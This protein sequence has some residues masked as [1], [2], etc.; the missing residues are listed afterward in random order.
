[1][2]NYIP[3]VVCMFL[4]QGFLINC[5]Q[6]CSTGQ[7]P[8]ILN[9]TEGRIA[10]PGHPSY[11]P[12]NANISW[13][14]QVPH[15]YSIK[16]EFSDNFKIGLETNCRSD[17]LVI[18]DGFT[19]GSPVM[20]NYCGSDKPPSLYSS[21]PTLLVAFISDNEY[22]SSGFS[23]NYTA[24]KPGTTCSALQTQ[25]ENANLILRDASGNIFAHFN[26]SYNYNIKPLRCLWRLRAPPGYGIK[27]AINALKLDKNTSC[28]QSNFNVYKGY[29]VQ[30][31]KLVSRYC[32]IENPAKI[33]LPDRTA[34]LRV[35][36]NQLSSWIGSEAFAIKYEFLKKDINKC[37]TLNS[38]QENSNII[39]TRN[40]GSFTIHTENGDPD[41]G[42]Q[43]LWKIKPP[44]GHQ[45]RLSFTKFLLESDCRDSFVEIFD[46]ENSEGN[47]KFC[48]SVPPWVMFSTGGYLVVKFVARS[49][50]MRNLSRLSIVGVYEAVTYAK[51][52]CS[53]INTKQMNSNIQLNDKKGVI[54]TPNY[55][56]KYPSDFKCVW[57]ITVPSGYRIR[58]HFV[59]FNVENHGC[60]Y[61]FVEVRD[62]D[63]SSSPLKTQ[64]NLCGITIPY[65][66][67]STSNN[68]WMMFVSDYS[69]Q[70]TGFQAFYSAVT[71]EPWRCSPV[72]TDQE[73]NI[74]IK[75]TPGVLT[76]PNY[77]H[78]YPP[79][80][81]CTWHITVP[82]SLRIQVHFHDFQ[83][84]SS[85]SFE[86]VEGFDGKDISDQSLGRYCGSNLP[87]DM[88]STGNAITLVFQSSTF[89]GCRGFKLSHFILELGPGICSKGNPHDLNDNLV[90]NSTRGNITSPN[91]PLPYTRG[92]Q[93]TWHVRAPIGYHV[94]LNF[95]SIHFPLPCAQDYIEVRDGGSSNSPFKGRFC[96]VQ[97]AS[98]IYSSGRELWLRFISQHTTSEAYKGFYVTYRMIKAG[99][100]SRDFDQ[101]WNTNLNFGESMSGSLTSPGYPAP[102]PPDIK[103]TWKITVHY[104]Y[105]VQL[106]FNRIS[107]LEPCTSGYVE[108]RDGYYSF[109]KSLGKFCKTEVSSV[110]FRSTDRR[111]F[112]HFESGNTSMLG[113]GFDASFSAMIKGTTSSG[114]LAA[115]AI[116]ISLIVFAGF[117]L[118]TLAIIFTYWL[119]KK[120]YRR[121]PNSRP[122]DHDLAVI[123]PMR[124]PP[125]D[126]IPDCLIAEDRPPPYA[127]AV[128]QD[129]EEQSPARDVGRRNSGC[130]EETVEER[131][132]EAE[133]GLDNEGF[134]NDP[135]TYESL[136]GVDPT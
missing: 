49:S 62:G 11:Y 12:N 123:P 132:I 17:Y 79:N 71:P 104:G 103:C 39:L 106:I 78:P 16:L 83:L 38:E 80:L 136:Y 23:A 109:S 87:F 42:L 116:T 36:I 86:F 97:S 118:I 58:L 26:N 46:G 68:M 60:V 29:F 48:G 3:R 72:N 127:E 22:Q 96:N 10:S 76:T 63:N 99:N 5:N 57:I 28:L 93:C 41:Q 6:G 73:N 134:T 61:D 107:L 4:F 92:M 122:R 94:E 45:V 119:L 53:T 7:Y 35:Q 114:S 108:V 15:G 69:E 43:C 128:N 31:D 135:P 111:L 33:Y 59:A 37:S 9:G 52:T 2:S 64:E 56:S 120:R 67:Y 20:G 89:A 110:R 91:Y 34:V 25:E 8:C 24:I 117:I 102:F 21:G 113:Q 66:I 55:P 90:V 1:M 32:K 112:V 98:R 74:L 81:K 50:N 115:G 88:F 30:E 75:D 121:R 54:M 85:C 47:G 27:I 70:M 44:N 100:C 131:S 18:Y 51:G 82:S 124:V 126:D 129:D 13:S 65:D 40:N 77:P 19:T 130:T 101:S 95:T 133:R 84:Y 105:Q 14:I 125:L